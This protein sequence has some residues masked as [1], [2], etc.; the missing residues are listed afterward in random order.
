MR[1]SH[2]TQLALNSLHT[3]K[4]AG[5]TNISE[6][7][8]SHTGCHKNSFLGRLQAFLFEPVV[9]Y[10]SCRTSG[11]DGSTATEPLLSATRGD[12]AS[13]SVRRWV[14]TARREEDS[15]E[16]NAVHPRLECRWVIL[17]EMA[18]RQLKDSA[19]IRF[20]GVSFFCSIV[21]RAQS[22]VASFFVASL[23]KSFC[24][25]VYRAQF[26]HHHCVTALQQKGGARIVRT[27]RG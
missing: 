7:L 3:W 17:R 25:L 10:H 19:Y 14:A 24:T 2:L 1:L 22:F 21:H 12:P 8:F 4:I 5:G 23:C 26:V 20:V 18:R 11:L 27:M 9:V 16:G 15:D 6:Y 13:S